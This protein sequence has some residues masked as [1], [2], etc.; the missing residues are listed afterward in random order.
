VD[1]NSLKAAFL[2]GVFQVIALLCEDTD[3]VP[4]VERKITIV[5]FPNLAVVGY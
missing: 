1:Q 4:T 5:V 2:D 3:F